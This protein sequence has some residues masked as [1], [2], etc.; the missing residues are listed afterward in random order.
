L[1]QVRVGAVRL[2]APAALRGNAS[3]LTLH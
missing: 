1:H 2:V 3:L